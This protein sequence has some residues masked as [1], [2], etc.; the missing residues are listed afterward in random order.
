MAS[1]TLTV[2]GKCKHGWYKQQDA[3]KALL[4]SYDPMFG[5]GPSCTVKMTSPD[6]KQSAIYMV[7]KTYALAIQP[8]DHGPVGMWNLKNRTKLAAL[9]MQ[10]DTCIS[11]K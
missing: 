3:N 9:S 1:W 8:W 4:G 7:G 10:P 2:Q 5:P 6:G 11:K